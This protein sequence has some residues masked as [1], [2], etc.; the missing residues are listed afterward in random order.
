MR[1]HLEPEILALY[2]GGDLA[3]TD[4]RAVAEH[5]AECQAC[6]RE[7]A[8]IRRSVA[9]FQGWA[10]DH[11]PAVEEIQALHAA[12]MARLPRA[13]RGWVPAWAAAAA[14]VVICAS[15]ALWAPWR[16]P[17]DY[18][19]T[20]AVVDGAKSH[21]D[22]A[23]LT[24]QPKTLI[25]PS[26]NVS[27]R[28]LGNRDQGSEKITAAV[29][30]S[31]RSAKPGS[32]SVSLTHDADGEPVLEIATANPNVLILWYVDEGSKKEDDDE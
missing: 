18:P 15:V 6:G 24:I 20:P 23:A 10:S 17:Q 4:A 7:L 28:E 14:A 9:E 13:Q 27:G 3:E 30:K 8:E 12:V 16:T 11:G 22:I 26:R 25:N 5:V 31:N 29:R 1:P 32:R 21:G 19:Q 2:A